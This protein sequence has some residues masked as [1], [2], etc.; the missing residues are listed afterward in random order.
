MASKYFDAILTELPPLIN[1]SD[2]HIS[3]V[4]SIFLRC[5]IFVSLNLHF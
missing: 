4:D 5:S 2:L 1:E 3:Q